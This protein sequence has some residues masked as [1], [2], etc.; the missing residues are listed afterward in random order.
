MPGAGWRHNAIVANLI[1]AIGLRLRGKSFAACGSEMR[2][3]VAAS[4][5]FYYPDVSVS[6][7]PP[8][9]AHDRGESLLNPVVII[10]VLSPSTEAIDRGEKL[11][12]YAQIRGLSEY[13]IVDP[14]AV[15]IDLYSR[16]ENDAWRLELLSNSEAKLRLRSLGIELPL[17]EIYDRVLLGEGTS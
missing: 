2:V 1:V 7:V 6:P 10:E 11:A 8:S 13:M 3:R 9:I 15:R 4:G 16:I 14:N 17:A 5:P 12:N